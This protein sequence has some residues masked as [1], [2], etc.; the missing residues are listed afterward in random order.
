MQEILLREAAVLIASAAGAYTDFKTGYIYDWVTLPLIALGLLADIYEQQFTGIALGAIVFG[1]GYALYYT[2]KLGGGDVKLYT[3]IA[4][5]MPSYGGGLFILSAAF[6]G[7]LCAVVFFSAYYVT[8]YA[9]KG[10]DTQYNSKGIL[11]SALLLVFIAAYF[12]ALYSYGFISP[13]YAATLGVPMLFG[14]AFA[15]L[16]K[17]IRKEFFVKRIRVSELEDDELL[18]HDFMREEERKAVQEKAGLG[19]KAVIGESEKA[20]LYGAGIIE[21][22][23]YRNLP[24]FGPFIFLGVLLA[25]AMPGFPQIMTGGI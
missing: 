10:I 18:A 5:I 1:L 13:Q 20:K 8:G 17:G 4:L 21:V 24:R 12:Y 3:G 25:L 9:R 11:R 16:E 19:L 6:L 7:G 23:V 22:A 15:A 2:G 14:L